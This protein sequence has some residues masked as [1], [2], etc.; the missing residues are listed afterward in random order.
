M[1]QPSPPYVIGQVV[2][3]PP[4]ANLELATILQNKRG[5]IVA[6]AKSKHNN[7]HIK[8]A[9]KIM[10]GLAENERRRTN[11][12]EKARTFLRQKG[13]VPVCKVDGVHLV[14]R[15]RF[16]TEKEVIAFARAKGWK[17]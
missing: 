4:D 14:G 3:I 15:Q 16:K 1:K 7:Q 5:M 9:K 12:F 10:D 6:Q 17:S 8:A 13:F 11:P 2:A